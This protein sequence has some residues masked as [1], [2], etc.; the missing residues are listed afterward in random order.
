M[1]LSW[2]F[3]EPHKDFKLESWFLLYHT[4]LLQNFY[5]LSFI[6]NTELFGGNERW[7]SAIWN[8]HFVV[9]RTEYTNSLAAIGNGSGNSFIEHSQQMNWLKT[10]WGTSGSELD[11]LNTSLSEMT[12]SKI[13]LHISLCIDQTIC[14]RGI[15]AVS[16]SINCIWM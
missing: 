13:N 1:P 9:N 6:I 8:I 12:T 11:W 5:Y 10:T 14:K 15:L 2:R 7:E 16:I 3:R 4:S